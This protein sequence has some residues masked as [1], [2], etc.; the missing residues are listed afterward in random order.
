MKGL[1]PCQCL[2]TLEVIWPH[3]LLILQ[4]PLINRNTFMTRFFFEDNI[5]YL[6]MHIGELYS[7]GFAAKE[8]K[9]HLR[10]TSTSMR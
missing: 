9:V 6:N 8:V 5:R 10:V 3:H 2:K 1:V 4:M 7:F